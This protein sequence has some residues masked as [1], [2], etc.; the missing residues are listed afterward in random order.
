[1]LF[2][3]HAISLIESD[4]SGQRFAASGFSSPGS[5]SSRSIS[6]SGHRIELS[7]Q[8]HHASSW[9]DGLLFPFYPHIDAVL[10]NPRVAELSCYIAPRSS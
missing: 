4:E 6:S 8:Q 7:F 1:M 3:R 9:S 10:V 2:F 5:F